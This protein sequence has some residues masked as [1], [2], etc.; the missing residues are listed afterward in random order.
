MKRFW[1][2]IM[3]GLLCA[4]WR[5]GA[6]EAITVDRGAVIYGMERS[7][8]QGYEPANGNGVYTLCLPVRSNRTQGSVQ[9][10]LVMDDPAVTPFREQEMSARF[11]RN[12]EGIYPVRLRLRLLSECE[13][14]DYPASVYI[15][16]KDE[17]GNALSMRYPL[18]VHI[19]T[20][21][22]ATL[23]PAPMVSKVYA[24]LRAGETSALTA[25]L[26]N[27]YSNAE[28]RD[29]LV[30]VYDESGEILPAGAQWMK[31]EALAPGE[32]A[33][34]KTELTALPK[35]SVVPHGLTFQVDYT[36]LEERRSW[37]ETCYIP[38]EQQIR[39]ENGGVQMAESVLQGDTLS[40]S[41][42]LMNMG[43]GLIR[44]AMVT[45]E[46]TGG[47]NVQSLLAGDIPS[48]ESKPLKFSIPISKFAEPNVYSGALTITAED[49]WGNSVEEILP[50]ACEIQERPAEQTAETEAGESSKGRL[51]TIHYA[52]IGVCGLC[53]ALLILQGLVLKG[54]LNRLEEERL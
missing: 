2:L 18:L 38:V 36:A 44:N 31:I 52:L 26:T 50:I 20:E 12:S 48:G 41:L 8:A 15:D 13:S 29:V 28:M 37:T 7:W 23:E 21:L 4:T 11:S 46:M 51:D 1:L 5:V 14:G 54:K 9:A 17:A 22:R 34:L 10:T 27:P 45:A 35:A 43:R 16:G 33:Q 47:F 49:E 42:S 24:A 6:D 25:R 39:L 19:R 3:V 30:C 32:S 53:I 40:I